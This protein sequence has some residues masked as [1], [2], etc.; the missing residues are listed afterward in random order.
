MEGSYDN[1]RINNQR[2]SDPSNSG[3]GII[4]DIKKFAI[5]DGPGIRT[6]VFLKGCP[7]SCW[8]CHNPESQ[9]FEIQNFSISKSEKEHSQISD[10]PIGR[11]ISVEEVMSEVIKDQIFYEESGGGVTFSG[12]EPLSQPNF[13]YSLLV[14]C[15]REEIHT[16]VDTSGCISTEEIIKFA[17]FIDLFLYDLKLLNNIKHEKYIGI[18]NEIVLKNLEVLVDLKKEIY[19][20]IPIIPTINDMDEE[21]TGIAEYLSKLKIIEKI[22]LLPYHKIGKDK[23][24]RLQLPYKM[25]DIPEPTQK[26]M[27]KVKSKFEIY[28][29]NVSIGG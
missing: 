8:W 15:K 6:T 5:H 29:F 19:I 4:F 17:N 2:F 26:Q 9:S 22:D 1:N 28:G 3:Q 24:S 23:Y 11:L 20:R 14:K 21:I 10:K 25:G 7:L 16:A 12:G 18:S 27:E 13:L